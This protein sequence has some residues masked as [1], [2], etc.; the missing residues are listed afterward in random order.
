MPRFGLHLRSE[1]FPGRVGALLRGGVRG[2]VRALSIERAAPLAA[3]SLS[4]ARPAFCTGPLRWVPDCRLTVSA[5]EERQKGTAASC[6]F[7]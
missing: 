4:S 6:D 1:R 7:Y 3:T 5:V 2:A